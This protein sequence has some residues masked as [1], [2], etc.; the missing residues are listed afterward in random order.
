M[1]SKLSSQG[2]TLFA[3]GNYEQALDKYHQALKYC[4]EQSMKKEIS[5]LQANCSQACLMLHKYIE[6]YT[7]CCECIKLD[8]TNF[9]GYYRRAQA[10]KCLLP[11]AT[12]YGTY[13][14]VVKDYLKS[15][16]L[17]PLPDALTQAVILAVKH[18]M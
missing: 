15:F 18:G 1:F 17:N 7:H 4:H 6:A 9:T 8:E 12:E 3:G 13:T 2:N 16:D 11:T 14:D 10:L 5:T